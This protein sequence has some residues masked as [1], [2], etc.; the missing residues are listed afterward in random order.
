MCFQK[1]FTLLVIKRYTKYTIEVI[2]K[3]F[4]DDWKV[5]E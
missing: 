5:V 3:V 4:Y 2:K 1:V